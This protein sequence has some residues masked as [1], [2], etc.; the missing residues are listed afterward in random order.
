MLILDSLATSIGKTFPALSGLK[1][2]NEFC[3]KSCIGS[4]YQHRRVLLL[5]T[6]LKIDAVLWFVADRLCQ[7][8][9][10]HFYV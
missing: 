1:H 5:K 6:N 8:I 3:A 7:E 10:M 4:D 9:E 2:F